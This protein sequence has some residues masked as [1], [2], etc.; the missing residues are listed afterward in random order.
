VGEHVYRAVLAAHE[1]DGVLHEETSI[2]FS[3]IVKAH[4]AHL[5][6]WGWPSAIG[7]GE[8]FTLKIGIKCSSGC[9][10]GGRKFRI[11][12]QE[13]AE[14]AAGT[15]RDEIWPGTSALY[16]AEVEAEAPSA[17]GEHKWRVETPGSDSGVPHA[18]G[19]FAFA[20][21]VVSPPDY[22]VTVEAF[23]SAKQ[24]PI[25]GIHVLLH[26]YRAITDENGVA[27]VKVAKGRYKLVVS[28][29]KY[30]PY[31]GII[32]AAGDVTMRAELAVEP[33]GHEDYPG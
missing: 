9:N 33:E 21:K 11:L 10:L 25:K 3:F 8:R 23:D 29:F 7:A 32:D 24:T 13:G 6:A 19:S 28:G 12:D 31:Q 2:E 5:S 15:L 30:I 16:F 17:T 20:V 1:V 4:A 27:R 26:P 22:E 18:A 14:V